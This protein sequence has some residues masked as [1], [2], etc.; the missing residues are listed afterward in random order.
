MHEE[1][2][3]PWHL[4]VTVRMAVAFFAVSS[5]VGSRHLLRRQG[6]ERVDK[7]C[8]SSGAPGR[9]L[10]GKQHLQMPTS[11]IRFERRKYSTQRHR[12]RARRLNYCYR[13]VQFTMETWLNVYNSARTLSTS[14][15]RSSKTQTWTGRPGRTSPCT[16]RP[17]WVHEAM[18]YEDETVGRYCLVIL[19]PEPGRLGQL[20]RRPPAL[21]SG[22]AHP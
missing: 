4:A 2:R 1:D 10:N 8:E 5:T 20:P 22:R 6:I 9:K 12:L 18:Q 15:P 11:R 17:I 16:H 19:Y 3:R 7:F 13:K 14:V 21:D